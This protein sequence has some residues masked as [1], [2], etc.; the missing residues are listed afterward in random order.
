MDGPKNKSADT[1]PA[2]TG[3]WQL[4]PRGIVLLR[5]NAEQIIVLVLLPTL[6]IQLGAILL[7]RQFWLG[8]AVYGI[9]LAWTLV[10]TPVLYHFSINAA[11]GKTMLAGEAYRQGLRF[12]GR[13]VVYELV[14]GVLVFVGLV[15]LIVPGLVLLRRYILGP[16][17]I[18][19]QDLAILNAAQASAART[20]PIAGVIW[21]TLGVMACVMVVAAIVSLVLGVVPALATL[22]T[23][24]VSLAGIFILPLRYVEIVG[25]HQRGKRRKAAER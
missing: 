14:F 4:L 21:A 12:F 6:T 18:V 9:G 25:M 17:F 7:G 23:T 16:Y 11:R 15:L 20:A 22:A 8:L 13:V 3:S 1:Q 10:N 19:D 24:L 5:Q 2:M